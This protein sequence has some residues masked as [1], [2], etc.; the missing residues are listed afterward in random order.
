VIFGIIE[1][2]FL[3]WIRLQPSLDVNGQRNEIVFLS[4]E[5]E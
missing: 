1:K 3:V 4:W 2:L 5:L